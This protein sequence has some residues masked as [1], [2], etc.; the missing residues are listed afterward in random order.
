M[1]VEA[2]DMGDAEAQYELGRRL[3]YEVSFL[4]IDIVIIFVLI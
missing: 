2:A 3:R 1:L 4:K